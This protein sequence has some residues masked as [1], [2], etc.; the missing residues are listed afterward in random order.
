MSENTMDPETRIIE[1]ANKVFLKYG[2]DGTTMSQIA[3]EANISRTSLHYYFRNKAK[4]FQK[5]LETIQTRV[6]PTLSEI[7]DAEVPVLS[8]IE[9]FIN[10]YIDLIMNNPMIPGF[11]FM[12]MQR[13]AKWIVNLFRMQNLKFDKLTIQIE[14]EIGEGKIKPFKLEDLF[15]NIMGMSV[16][17][18][19][20]KPVFM[21]FIFNHNEVDFY[22][23]MISRKKTIM[24]VIDNWLTPG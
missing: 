3:E 15:T 13:D 7:I 1:A 22:D 24:S 12:E 6:I 20:G 19:L 8:K 16:F 5:V 9:M 17:P 14:K 4:L 23:F 21:E 10:A 18:L 2:V 11:L